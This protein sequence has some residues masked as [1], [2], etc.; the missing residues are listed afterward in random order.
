MIDELLLHSARG[1]WA[2]PPNK[3]LYLKRQ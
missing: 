2:K 3:E 1:Q